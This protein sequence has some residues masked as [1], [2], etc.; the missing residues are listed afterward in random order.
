MNMKKIL[1]Y[2]LICLGLFANA[3]PGKDGPYTAGTANQVLNKYCPVAANITAGANT[4]T[5]A[6]GP[7]FSLC[8]GDL[9]MVYQAQGATI[10]FSDAISYGSV[11]AYNSAGLY[12]F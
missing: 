7:G 6:T 3:Q 11:N 1:F 9:I 10:S 4:L 2:S 5:L 12:E 8:P